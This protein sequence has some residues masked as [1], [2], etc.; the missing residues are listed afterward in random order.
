MPPNYGVAEPYYYPP[1]PDEEAI[2]GETVRQGDEEPT[3]PYY[4]PQQPYPY[5]F[6][7]LKV[8]LKPRRE[9]EAPNFVFYK[10]SRRIQI[11]RDKRKDQETS[12]K[13]FTRLR[14]VR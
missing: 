3:V 6:Q 9:G 2:G 14:T 12:S 1:G 7:P 8:P 10:Q 13:Y 5:N 11:L 4:N